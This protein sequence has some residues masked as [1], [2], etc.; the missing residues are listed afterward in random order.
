MNWNDG[1][2]DPSNLLTLYD[3]A[4]LD[5]NTAEEAPAWL[6]RR[7]HRPADAPPD[8]VKARLAEQ[9]LLPPV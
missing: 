9:N 7:C 6:F 1:L 8:H 5:W 3:P 4:R 2:V